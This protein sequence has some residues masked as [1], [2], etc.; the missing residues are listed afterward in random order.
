MLPVAASGSPGPPVRADSAVTH[1]VCQ[2]AR[3]ATVD[4]RRYLVEQLQAIDDAAARGDQRAIVVAAEA[5]QDRLLTL[6]ASMALWAS[7]PV[8][9][10]VRTALV[11]AAATLRAICAESYAG[12]PDD[13]DRELGELGRS[14]AGACGAPAA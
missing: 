2:A 3:S 6:A 10:P 12:T 1:R 11:R 5:V 8:S 14:F 9:P 13:I 4:G 7:Q